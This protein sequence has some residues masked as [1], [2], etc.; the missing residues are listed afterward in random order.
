MKALILNDLVIDVADTEFEVHESMTWM[1][2][3]TECE[4]GWEVVA[5]K[6]QAIAEVDDPRTYVEFRRA[7]YSSVGDQLDML[8]HEIKDTG[9]ISATGTWATMIQGVKD[10]NPKPT[11]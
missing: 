10:A 11:N 7:E 4:A 1:D 5:G 8:F 3:P 2:A 9:S 6:L